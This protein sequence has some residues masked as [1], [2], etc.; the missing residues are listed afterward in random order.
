MTLSIATLE[1]FCDGDPEA[2][3]ALVRGFDSLVRS[4]VARYFRGAFEREEAMQE[5]WLRAFQK[6]AALDP[7]RAAELPG[8][9]ATLSRHACVDLL[10]RAPRERPL[11]TAEGEAEV[12][13]A[14]DAEQPA[15]V[16]ARELG[17]AV[18]AFEAQ[19]EGPWRAFFR[20]HFVE[21]I[22]YEEIAQR[23]D[24]SRLRCKYMKK[25]LAARAR[26]SVAL[27]AALGRY[28]R[29]GGDLAP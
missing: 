4:I 6:R 20:L 27:L 28:V 8:W 17:E 23:L 16:E 7:S 5:I 9:L 12:E 10:R 2:F 13:L 25:V 24:I 3:A 19:L 1:R 21:G 15:L 22:P 18:V 11:P 29:A 26:E 14:A